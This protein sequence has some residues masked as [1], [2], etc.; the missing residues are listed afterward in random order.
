M[1][2]SM[3]GGQSKETI[4]KFVRMYVNDVTIEMG[5]LGEQAIKNLFKFGI[6][7]DLVPEFELRIA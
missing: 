6:E 5:I 2:C 3:A 4:D 7:K 1:Q